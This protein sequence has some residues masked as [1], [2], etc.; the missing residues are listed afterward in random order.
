MQIVKQALDLL[1]SLQ[2]LVHAYMQKPLLV[3]HA[4]TTVTTTSLT[5]N[6]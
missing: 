2:Q 4:L 6:N 3:T 5:R 1:G